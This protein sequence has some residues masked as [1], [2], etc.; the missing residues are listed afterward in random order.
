KQ[1]FA[2]RDD[3]WVP[4]SERE[5]VKIS[6]TNI[7]LLQ[8][9]DSYEFL[10]ANKKCTVNVE[11]FRIIL[12]IC[13][14]VEGVDFMDVSDDGT[15]LTFLID[16]GYKNH[17]RCSLSIQQVKF[18]LRR[19]KA[20]VQKARKLLMTLRKLLMYLKSLNLNQNLPKKTASRRMV[21]KKVT[22]TVADKIIP[23]PDVA[24][25]SSKSKN[26]GVP[27]L[28][29]KEQEAADIMKALKE[30][31]RQPGIE[32]SSKRTG[33]KP[34][35]LDESIVV[36]ATSN[37]ETGIKP[38]VPDE[39]QDIT[40]EKVILVWG[41]EQDIEYFNDDNDD[42]DKNDKDGD[43]DDEGGDYINDTQD[44]DD[45]DVKTKSDE[46]DIYKYKISVHK[47][48]EEEMLNDEV[49]DFNKG[50]EKVSNVAKAD[51]E[52]T[53]K[54]KD[55]AKKTEL[56]PSSSSLSVS[57]GFGDQFIKLSF[58]S[59]LVSKFSKQ[60]VYSTNAILGVKSVSVKKLQGYGHLEEIVVKRSDQQLHK[61]KEDLQ[62]GVKSYQKKL[63]IT[64]P[65]K[66]F[67]KIEFKERYTPSYDPPGIV[68]E[69]LN[70]QKRVLRADELYK[71][72]DGT[73]KSVRD[74]IH[75]RVLDFCLD[76]NMEMPTR[77][78]TAVDRKVGSYD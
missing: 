78:W 39:E 16:L 30:S 19:G 48:E 37:E 25:E 47:D 53:S 38:G 23:D 7:R 54:V 44:T 18:L 61:F 35:V 55:D 4:F 51:A 50:D 24:L 40:E 27:S 69:D 2:A 43:A 26:K 52:K 45:E 1:Q 49:N 77:K 28:T 46:D 5:R 59:S 31:K 73:L 33:T 6:S 58:D 8:G 13:L 70:K 62:L 67:P 10:L 75:Y 22:I 65:Q 21:K 29:L 3:K 72:L 57:S 11:V 32:G 14:R 74:K 71:F 34:R 36:F 41:D 64:K 20:K 42:V 12:E 56:P 68:Y 60:N 63:N 15:T 17:S 66:T 9:T 76:Y